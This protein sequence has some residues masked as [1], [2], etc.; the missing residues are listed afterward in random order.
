MDAPAAPPVQAADIK[1]II[2]SDSALPCLHP[3]S[4]GVP[5]G[6]QREL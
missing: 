6:R 2:G 5:S 3:I 4:S 1:A